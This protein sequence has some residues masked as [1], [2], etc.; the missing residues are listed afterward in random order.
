LKFSQSEIPTQEGKFASYV[1]NWTA[2]DTLGY[3]TTVSDTMSFEKSVA[4][5]SDN[6]NFEYSL[7]E[8]YPNPFNPETVIKFSIPNSVQVQITIY[9]C[10]GELIDIICNKSFSKG[11]HYI[12]WNAASKISGL[13]FY[14]MQAGDYVKVKKMILIK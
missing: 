4:V 1:A 2:T 8:N 6:I 7:S 12:K 14:K 11:I 5:E 13:Y 9:N 3:E 10:K